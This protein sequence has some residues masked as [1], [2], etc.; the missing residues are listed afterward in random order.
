MFGI[1]RI[2]PLFPEFSFERNPDDAVKTALFSRA[3]N[4]L[5]FKGTELSRSI[6]MFPAFPSPVVLT[7]I[8]DPFKEI[9]PALIKTSPPELELEAAALKENL[10]KVTVLDLKVIVPAEL[11]LLALVLTPP[12]V[13]EIEFAA[14]KVISP[15]PLCRI[16]ALRRLILDALRAYPKT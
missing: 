13:R 16:A 4:G 6:V 3:R 5:P 1:I 2:V 14:S 12:L 15:P 11:L 7:F 8:D 9:E 10:S